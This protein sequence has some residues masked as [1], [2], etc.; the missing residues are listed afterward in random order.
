MD[1]QTLISR[2]R[3]RLPLFWRMLG[4]G[5][6]FKNLPSLLEQDET[7]RAICVG[8]ASDQRNYLIAAT[9]RRIVVAELTMFGAMKTPLSFQLSN[10]SINAEP[11]KGRLTLQ[12]GDYVLAITRAQ[13]EQIADLQ[14]ALSR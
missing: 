12:T 10:A 7:L 9:D 5:R 3:A 6:S 1:T 8:N 13:K 11:S 14:L 4:L 2:E